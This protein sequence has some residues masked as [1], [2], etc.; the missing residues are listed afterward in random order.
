MMTST[1]YRLTLMYLIDILL[2]YKSLVCKSVTL[3]LILTDNLGYLNISHKF[4]CH[5]QWYQYNQYNL[6]DT[7]NNVA[8]LFV[9]SHN[10]KTWNSHEENKYNLASRQNIGNYILQQEKYRK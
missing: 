2:V 1:F 5:C 8:N 4:D 7:T 9:A 3:S 6:T 10:A